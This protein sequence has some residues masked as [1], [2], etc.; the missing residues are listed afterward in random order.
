MFRLKT[1]KT[2]DDDQNF[3]GQQCRES[4]PARAWSGTNNVNTLVLA[5]TMAQSSDAN[6]V[7]SFARNLKL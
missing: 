6:N 7:K 2:M 1:G 5:Q 4:F 3:S